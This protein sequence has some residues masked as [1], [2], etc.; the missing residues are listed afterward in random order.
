MLLHESCPKMAWESTFANINRVGV[1]FPWRPHRIPM[2][3]VI[4][5]KMASPVMPATAMGRYTPLRSSSGEY[6]AAAAVAAAAVSAAATD[7]HQSP[8]RQKQRGADGGARAMPKEPQSARRLVHNSGSAAGTGN[9]SSRWDQSQNRDGHDTAGGTSA[10]TA[11]G[12]QPVAPS[13]MIVEAPYQAGPPPSQVA[14][15]ADRGGAAS[16]VSRRSAGNRR[17]KNKYAHLAKGTS[18]S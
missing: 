12:V 4:V 1:N 3:K 15:A 13:D 18:H 7:T 2:G 17:R 16:G 10:A 6:A 14:P 11:M 9:V 8:P 5:G